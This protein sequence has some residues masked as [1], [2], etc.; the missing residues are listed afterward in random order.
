MANNQ[1]KTN[2]YAGSTNG[3]PFDIAWITQQQRITPETIGPPA[4]EIVFIAQSIKSA[5]TNGKN[6]YLL[7]MPRGATPIVEGIK[8]AW[9]KLYGDQR[10][11][12][13]TILVPI[14]RE[15][16]SDSLVKQVFRERLEEI[17]ENATVFYVDEVVSG[18]NASANIDDLYKIL[19][20]RK[21]ELI[22]HL[23]ISRNENS[24]IY[25]D[26]LDYVNRGRFRKVNFP[27]TGY[28]VYYGYRDLAALSSL[29]EAIERTG[30][31]KKYGVVI[32]KRTLLIKGHAIHIP[33]LKTHLTDTHPSHEITRGR[34]EYKHHLSSDPYTLIDF[35]RSGEERFPTV[36]RLLQPHSAGSYDL[37]HALKA[38]IGKEVHKVRHPSR[39]R[40]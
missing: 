35:S 6:V 40:A 15:N 26:K 23:L 8:Y 27:S 16:S 25:K 9:K 21:C 3:R 1:T 32:H 14:S 24:T 29:K 22:T 7:H 19:K 18:R 12:F 17:P 5:V 28:N 38:S 4:Q 11:A 10:L 34:T 13:K 2:S 20:K 30:F 39:R 36:L 33:R 37:M 31:G